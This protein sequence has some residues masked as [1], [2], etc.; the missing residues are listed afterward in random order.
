MWYN[1]SIMQR[2]TE[3]AIDEYYHLY[4]RGV[5]KRIIFNDQNDY[6]RFLVLLYLSNSKQEVRLGDRFQRKSTLSDS[7][8]EEVSGEL[9]SIGGYCLMPNHFHLLVREK[10][11]NGISTF[12]KKLLTGYSMYFNKKYERTG[13]LF[14]GRFKAVHVNN[15]RYLEYLFS[16]LHL[17][18]VKLIDSHWRDNKFFE[19]TKAKDFLGGYRYSSYQF[20]CGQKRPENKILDSKNFPKYFSGKNDFKSFIDNW[21]SFSEIEREEYGG[22]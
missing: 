13:T 1:I 22:F 4:N 20:Y 19:K 12:M 8:R 7:F 6:R 10:V 2:K 5:D 15:D 21:L 3:F 18:P 17:N 14:E 9:V 11:E 16:Y